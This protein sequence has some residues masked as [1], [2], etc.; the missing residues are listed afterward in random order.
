MHTEFCERNMDHPSLIQAI[1]YQNTVPINFLATPYQIISDV[2]LKS[3]KIKRHTIIE[4]KATQGDEEIF[5][6]GLSQIERAI[7]VANRRKEKFI[8]CHITEELSDNPKFQFLPNPYDKK[9]SKAYR[10]LMQG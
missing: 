8:I 4:V 5:E 7:E 6:L 2:T 3:S 1:G 10:V 9:Y